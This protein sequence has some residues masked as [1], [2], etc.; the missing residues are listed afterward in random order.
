MDSPEVFHRNWPTKVPSGDKG[1]RANQFAAASSMIV[2]K[3][4]QLK[5]R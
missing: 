1:G 4:N 2:E 5:P 3:I